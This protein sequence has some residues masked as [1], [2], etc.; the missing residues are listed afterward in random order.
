MA[1]APMTL[2]QVVCSVVALGG[3]SLSKIPHTASNSF[4]ATMPAR[5][6]KT[7]PKGL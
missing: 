5:R 4:L 6:P 1:A 2:G 3:S 7:I